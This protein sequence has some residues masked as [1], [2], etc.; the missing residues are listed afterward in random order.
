MKALFALVILLSAN[1]FISCNN[2]RTSPRPDASHDTVVIVPKA[3]DDES[4]AAGFIRK[5]SLSE[6][7]VDE[8][9]AELVNT[10]PKLHKIEEQIDLVNQN[11]SL[12]TFRNYNAKSDNYYSSAKMI[13]ENISDSSIKKKALDLIATSAEKY[14]HTT[15]SLD[16]LRKTILGKEKDIS[17]L[18]EYL[19]I[20]STLPLMEK[21]QQDKLPSEK[22]LKDKIKNQDE[23]INQLGIKN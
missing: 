1:I 7:L 3:L 6:N 21:Y 4:K 13:A 23:V 17:N 9:Y 11:D 14:K 22:T 5:S 10:K 19:K 20:V 2:G 18:H 12:T 16:S 15:S 8:M